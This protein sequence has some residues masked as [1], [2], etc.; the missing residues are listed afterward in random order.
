MACPLVTRR[1]PRDLPAPQQ[2]QKISGGDLSIV[3]TMACV[4]GLMIGAVVLVELLG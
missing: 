3:L 4:V 2:R 1:Q